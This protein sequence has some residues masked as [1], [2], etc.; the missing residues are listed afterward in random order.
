MAIIVYVFSKFYSK[1]K[2]AAYILAFIL[3]GIVSPASFIPIFGMGFFVAM[4][5]PL[6]IAT[7]LNIAVAAVTGEYLEKKK[8]FINA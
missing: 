5:I 1:N 3:N 2:I 7:G 4:V 8:V 6:M